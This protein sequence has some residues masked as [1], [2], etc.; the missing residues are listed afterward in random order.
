MKLAVAIL[1]TIG[2]LALLTQWSDA[3]S[4][5]AKGNL[6]GFANVTGDVLS[7][8]GGIPSATT[9]AN[10]Y[11][12]A[13][14]N[15][16]GILVGVRRVDEGVYD[17]QFDRNPGVTAVV[18]PLNGFATVQRIGAGLFRVRITGADIE[19]RLSPR[20]TAFSIVLV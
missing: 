5:C 2:F 8:P 3:A 7:G 17:V 12:S 20:D 14:F 9:R 1:A 13:R 16:S 19:S 10:R 11:F 18:T 4:R 15:C 6:R